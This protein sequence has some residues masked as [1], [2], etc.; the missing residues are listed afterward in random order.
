MTDKQ[1]QKL[2]QKVT[3]KKKRREQQYFEKKIKERVINVEREIN[4][5]L[6]KDN[7]KI[8]IQILKNLRTLINFN[9]FF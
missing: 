3:V 1:K 8:L 6:Y 4:E 5:F 9:Q 7:F 2:S